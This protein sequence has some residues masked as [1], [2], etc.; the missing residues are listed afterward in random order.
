MPE[1]VLYLYQT[2]FSV[3]LSLLFYPNCQGQH[4]LLLSRINLLGEVLPDHH[5]R[6]R[7]R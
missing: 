7:G 2:L 4:S 6:Q 5:D 3:F 1:S